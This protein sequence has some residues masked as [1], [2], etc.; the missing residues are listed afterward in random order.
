M[1]TSAVADA[2]SQLE[3]HGAAKGT[4]FVIADYVPVVSTAKGIAEGAVDVVTL[5][6]DVYDYY[7]YGIDF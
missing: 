5:G 1:A 2:A 3:E 6:W 4:A 7:E